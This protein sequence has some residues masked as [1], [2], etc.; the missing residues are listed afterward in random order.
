MVGDSLAS[1]FSLSVR[2]IGEEFLECVDKDVVDRDTLRRLGKAM[3]PSA[4]PAD[5]LERESLE[6]VLFDDDAVSGIC[7]KGSRRETLLL[8]L[9]ISQGLSQIPTPEDFR[10]IL[11]A[12]QRSDGAPFRVPSPLA[13]QADRWQAFQANELAHIALESFLAL[14]VETIPTKPISVNTAITDV[15]QKVLGEFKTSYKTWTELRDRQHLA[16]NPGD[17]TQEGSEA[18]LAHNVLRTGSFESSA[19]AGLQLLAVLD[20]RWCGY[21]HSVAKVFGAGTDLGSHFPNA[22]VGLL[23]F[24]RSR[25]SSPLERTIAELVQRFVIEQHL[26]IALRKLH[27]QGKRTFLFEMNH[28]MLER[29][30]KTAPVFTN[31]RIATS[32]SFLQDLYLIAADGPT[33]HGKKRLQHL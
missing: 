29:P 12:R 16:S 30:V 4:I 11:Y 33:S 10:W 7:G 24:L 18:A 27:Q 9:L 3:C 2:G 17:P 32:I 19:A 14:L 1:A 25:E 22:V 8:C 21:S 15:V 20:K 26:R 6:K 28:G 23:T 13:D 5:S 31:P